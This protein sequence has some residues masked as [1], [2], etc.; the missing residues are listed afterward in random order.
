MIYENNFKTNKDVNNDYYDDVGVY[1]VFF[2]CIIDKL[3][4]LSIV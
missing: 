2:S 4:V 3:K 1:P